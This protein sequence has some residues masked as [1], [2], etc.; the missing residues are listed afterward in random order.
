[1]PHRGQNAPWDEVIT[2]DDEE[3]RSPPKIDE[4]S[5]AYKQIDEAHGIA[6][7]QTPLE[8]CTILSTAHDRKIVEGTWYV[9]TT[10]RF[11]I[12]DADTTK[13]G[14]KEC[15]AATDLD[16]K[17]D[18]GFGTSPSVM[19]INIVSAELLLRQGG[20]IG[21]QTTKCWYRL[22]QLVQEQIFVNTSL[23]NDALKQ[24]TTMTDSK[25]NKIKIA[26]TTFDM[27]MDL[28]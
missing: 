10:H 8:N 9:L 3:Y 16:E 19:V 14:Y 23:E 17:I 2:S 21:G 5:E 11:I 15:A 22:R 26:D 1:M 4:T 6:F 27:M 25:G 12:E 18:T 24:V 28:V 13:G 7:S 20:D